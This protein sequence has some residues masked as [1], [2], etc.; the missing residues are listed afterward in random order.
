MD[1]EYIHSYMNVRISE[2]IT[3]IFSFNNINIIF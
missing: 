1:Y 3:N 2:Q